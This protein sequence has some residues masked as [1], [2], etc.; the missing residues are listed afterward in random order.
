M[1][2]HHGTFALFILIP[3]HHHPL[4][5]AHPLTL[6]LQ[7]IIYDK[8]R[9]EITSKENFVGDTKETNNGQRK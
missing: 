2:C 7:M 4:H 9:T 3:T 5:F 8:Q 1:I 6:N